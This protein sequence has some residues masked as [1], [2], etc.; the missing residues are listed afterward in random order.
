MM[1]KEAIEEVFGPP[2]QTSDPL[3]EH[4]TASPPKPTKESS[5]AS[6]KYQELLEVADQSLAHKVQY[7]LQMIL[8]SQPPEEGFVLVDPQEY[9]FSAHEQD[10]SYN[11]TIEQTTPYEQQLA[12]DAS[13]R[14]EQRDL[15]TIILKA[16]GRLQ[17]EE[18]AIA[19]T[20]AK[21]KQGF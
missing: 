19:A 21:A 20:K 5:A 10:E 13:I 3:T 17:E 11:I 12:F 4:E 16:N 8:S 7:L 14:P 2:K 18:D 9:A 6:A 1:S 15:L